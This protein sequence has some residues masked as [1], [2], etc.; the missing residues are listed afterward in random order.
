M[1]FETS[2]GSKERLI[3]LGGRRVPDRAEVLSLS[4]NSNVNFR[5][6]LNS[7]SLCEM[8]LMFPVEQPQ[9]CWGKSDGN[10]LCLS[11][12]FMNYKLPYTLKAF[13]HVFTHSPMELC[14]ILSIWGG[15]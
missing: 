9:S 11:T 4:L 10:E 5:K 3:E 6:S 8:E 2:G 12:S 13:I 7:F 14:L 15:H 1:S